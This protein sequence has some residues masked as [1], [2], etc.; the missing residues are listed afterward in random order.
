MKTRAKQVRREKTFWVSRD[1][2]LTDGDNSVVSITKLKP[3][4]EG[5]E[6]CDHCKG[7]NGGSYPGSDGVDNPCYDGWV[8]LT[9]IIVKF[10]ETINVKVVRV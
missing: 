9:G 8:K 6:P 4:L 2:E 3:K 7:L 5:G 1:P 10:G